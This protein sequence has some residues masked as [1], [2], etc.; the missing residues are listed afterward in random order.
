MFINTADMAARTT[1]DEPIAIFRLSGINITPAA[2]AT[3]TTVVKPKPRATLVPTME[4]LRILRGWLVIIL[5]P[6]MVMMAKT[7][8]VAPPITAGG[9]VVRRLD[10]FGISPDIN[11]MIA[12][13]ENIFLL[14]TL[15]I[16]MIPTFW[17][18]VAVGRV[19]IKAPNILVI[20]KADSPPWS[21]L[22]L[23]SL[24]YPPIVVEDISPIPSIEVTI[25]IITKENIADGS[26]FIPKCI[27][28]TN[29]NQLAS[30]T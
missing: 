21:S 6:F 26:N 15:F 27:G 10:S 1:G 12:A 25:N 8:R 16:E 7:D 24:S 9:I 13:V 5:I 30:P 4:V 28:L 29:E 18:N 17:E 3:E 20:E 11:I 23:G 14:I 19:A 2:S 22:A